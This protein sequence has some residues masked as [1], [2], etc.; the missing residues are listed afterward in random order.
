MGYILRRMLVTIFFLGLVSSISAQ[1]SIGGECWSTANGVAA[2]GCATNTQCGPWLPDGGSW[3]GS[4]PWYCLA[5]P[6]LASGA[7]CDYATKN[8]LCD[9]GLTCCNGACASASTC[10]TTTAAPT[11]A[12]PTT[13][14]A[15]I[16]P[17][18][19][20]A[21]Q[22]TLGGECWSSANGV[23]SGGC[24]PGT[25]Y[26]PWLPNGGTW[27]GSSAW[28]CLAVPK[29]ASGAS[30]DYSDAIKRGLCD[31]GLTCCNNVCAT[32]CDST[33]T[34]SSTASS[35]ASSTTTTSTTTS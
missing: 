19:N 24:E 8:G 16:T 22:V 14:A 20:A 23:A 11:T 34:S 32:S 28:Y 12:A 15:P 26:G 35:T 21:G 2:G 3:D 1:V 7:T 13:T 9:T 5:T 33:T 31:T 29:L 17:G 25:Q 30:C 6:K 27:D 4:S 10:V 18:T